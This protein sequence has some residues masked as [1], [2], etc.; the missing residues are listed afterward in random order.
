MADELIE[1]PEKFLLT[2]D[3]LMEAEGGLRGLLLQ[4]SLVGLGV[5]SCF[6]GS[7]H[8]TACFRSGNLK[9]NQWLCLGGA[10][11]L[12]LMVG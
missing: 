5:G 10:A 2:Q 9:L 4:A 12:S 6:G 1:T 7:E 11:Y 3:Q 8:M